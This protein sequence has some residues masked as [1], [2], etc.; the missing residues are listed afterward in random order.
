MIST[1]VA[2]IRDKISNPNIAIVM[3]FDYTIAN[4]SSFHGPSF[5]MAIAGNM[6][7]RAIPPTVVLSIKIS[8]KLSGLDVAI[9]AILPCSSSMCT[10]SGMPGINKS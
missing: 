10:K 1:K 6:D 7:E 3:D 5:S 8:T 9:P 4:T 2:E